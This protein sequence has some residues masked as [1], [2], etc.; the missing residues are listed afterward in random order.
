MQFVDGNVV[1][2][3]KDGGSKNLGVVQK[4]W[5]RIELIQGFRFMGAQAVKSIPPLSFVLLYGSRI[6]KPY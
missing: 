5:Q 3:D 2:I 4:G 1:V 6:V